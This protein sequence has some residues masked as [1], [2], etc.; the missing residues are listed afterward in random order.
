MSES[1]TFYPGVTQSQ[2]MRTALNH[3]HPYPIAKGTQTMRV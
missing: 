1:M 2:D 3:L